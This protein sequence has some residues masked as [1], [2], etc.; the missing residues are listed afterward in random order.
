MHR[1]I[2]AAFWK[3]FQKVTQSGQ[4]YLVAD[5]ATAPFA[6]SIDSSS[7]RV[8]FLNDAFTKYPIP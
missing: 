2:E 6:N 3:P 5:R 8:D 4:S 1:D 7:S